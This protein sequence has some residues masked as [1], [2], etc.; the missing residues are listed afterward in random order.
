MGSPKVSRMRYEAAD[1]LAIVLEVPEPPMGFQSGY[2]PPPVI[3]FFRRVG[4]VQFVYQGTE[5]D[6]A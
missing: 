6:S 2:I 1:G 3:E 5:R 4:S